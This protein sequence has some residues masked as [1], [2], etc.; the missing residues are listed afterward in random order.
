MK[1]RLWVKLFLLVSVGVAGA[2]PAF[3]RHTQTSGL[4]FTPG[5]TLPSDEVHA[6]RDIDR[7]CPA[8]GNPP[9]P[10]RQ[11]QNRAKNNLCAAGVPVT[12]TYRMFLDLQ[13]AAERRG[14]P[15]GRQGDQQFLPPDRQVLKGLL[16]L[17]GNR[18]LGE[19]ALVRYV[20]FMSNPRTANLGKGESVNC[21]KTTKEENDIHI[22]LVRDPTEPACLSVTAEMIPHYRPTVWDP[23]ILRQVLDRPVRVT[24][25]LF[26]DASHYPCRGPNDLSTNPKRASLW[27]I[28][29]VYRF[30]VCRQKTIAA[31][32]ATDES[33]WVPLHHQFNVAEQ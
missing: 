24:G 18:R 15:H 2:A 21:N 27:E 13:K 12:M 20:A 8:Q 26:F 17:P 25:Q 1:H 31:C 29:P 23:D 22:D 28:H 9:E 10:D 7:T 6:V 32:S 19:G 5:C 3:G 11:A 4:A 14:I 33:K 30:D 16:P